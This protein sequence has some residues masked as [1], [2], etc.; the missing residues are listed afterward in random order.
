MADFLSQIP[1]DSSKF[2]QA[3]G[4]YTGSSSEQ[5]DDQDRLAGGDVI[6]SRAVFD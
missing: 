2:L 4:A 1:S 3:N 5:W 6:S